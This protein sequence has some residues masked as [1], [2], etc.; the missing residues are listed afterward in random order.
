MSPC[1]DSEVTETTVIAHQELL[2]IGEDVDTDHIMR[3]PLGVLLQE[4]VQHRRELKTLSCYTHKMI[5][6]TTHLCRTIIK[7]NTHVSVWCVIDI[8]GE[9]THAIRPCAHR[10]C[11]SVLLKPGRVDGC[12]AIR[13]S[14]RRDVR[15][16]PCV[17]SIVE[18]IDPCLGEVGGRRRRGRILSDPFCLEW[19]QRLTLRN[20]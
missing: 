3:R 2:I 5:E 17:H 12:R 13:R 1:V 4:I 14:G 11:I 8:P 7:P 16:T 19:C 15:D 9:L 10:W 6:H 20:G 18:C